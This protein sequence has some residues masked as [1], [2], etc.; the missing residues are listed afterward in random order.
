M[1]NL[2][3]IICCV[4]LTASSFANNSIVD[5]IP[6]DVCS[7]TVSIDCGADGTIDFEGTVSCGNVDA[8]IE[9]T[10]PLCGG[11]NTQL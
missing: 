6:P 8:Y 5:V 2:F 1:K 9:Q 4:L 11:S 7:V 10:L 3:S